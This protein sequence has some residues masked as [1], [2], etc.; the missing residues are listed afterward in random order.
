MD[1][2][3]QVHADLTATADTLSMVAAVPRLESRRAEVSTTRRW[4][5]NP[6][7]RDRL[8]LAAA[9]LLVLVCPGGAT[10]LWNRHEGRFVAGA[11]EMMRSGDWIIPRNDGMPVVFYP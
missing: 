3:L 2:S 8:L 6:G 10:T 9:A 5:G 7:T 11:W 1:L 4:I